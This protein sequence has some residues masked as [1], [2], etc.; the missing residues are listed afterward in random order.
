MTR[1]LLLHLAGP[2]VGGFPGLGAAIQVARN[3]RAELPDTRVEIVV[4]GPAVAELAA[5]G[6]L[7]PRVLE[8]L[9][10]PGVRFSA[11]ANSLRSAGL[12]AEALAAG[13]AVVPAAVARL[14]K[15]QYDG[16]AY[17]RI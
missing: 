9:G 17:V 13:V 4:Q 11:C 7:E 10:D 2:G 6:V 1:H 16:A 5:G 8:L 12:A 14:A 3:A 15:A